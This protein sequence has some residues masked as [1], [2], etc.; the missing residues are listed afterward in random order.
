MS[1]SASAA[2]AA[3]GSD[4]VAT[5]VS[6]CPMAPKPKSD[7][8]PLIQSLTPA[9][10]AEALPSLPA[11]TVAD[12]EV[13]TMTVGDYRR[14]RKMMTRAHEDLLCA[15][16][17]QSEAAREH[18]AVREE[19]EALKAAKPA[20][21]VK[22]A[23][24]AS[25]GAGDSDSVSTGS[26]KGSKGWNQSNDAWT[27]DDCLAFYWEHETLDSD[28]AKHARWG[29]TARNRCI[30]ARWLMN[31]DYTDGGESGKITVPGTT[32]L[33]QVEEFITTNFPTMRAAGER[34]T[35]SAGK[36]KIVKVP[37]ADD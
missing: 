16:E 36:G 2:C 6:A 10:L 23:A 17:M 37:E 35:R 25:G 29:K 8:I 13:M 9:Q 26:S 20:R 12:T 18:L 7:R 34:G 28:W 11:K 14:I 21:K 33:A 31:L 1:C 19:L 32:K 30:F 4:P 5:V 22:A 15:A 24:S 3:S 27:E